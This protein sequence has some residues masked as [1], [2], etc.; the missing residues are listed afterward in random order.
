MD[1]DTQIT[2]VL[3]R[4]STALQGVGTDDRFAQRLPVNPR[5]SVDERTGNVILIAGLDYESSPQ[6]I[7]NV[8]ITNINNRG[9]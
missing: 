9:K 4:L 3:L 6:E 2:S 7:I 8:E 5:F 1:E